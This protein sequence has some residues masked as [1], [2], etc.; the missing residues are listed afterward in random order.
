MVYFNLLFALNELYHPGEKRLLIHGERCPLRPPNLS[1]RRKEVARLAADD[2]A[3]ANML[4]ALID[5]LLVLVAQA[6]AAPD[7]LRS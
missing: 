5:D 1:A 6:K 3:L 2:P 7:P 4:A